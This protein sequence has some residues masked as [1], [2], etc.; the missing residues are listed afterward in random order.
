L[1][2]LFFAGTLFSQSITLTAPNG[3]QTW[4][5]CTEQ[6]ITWNSSGTSD[7]YSLD[8]STD[9]GNTWTS[10]TSYYNTSSGSYSWTVPNTSSSQCL[11]RITD[12][13]NS[14]TSDMSDGIF[15]ITSPL[16]VLAPNGSEVWEASTAETVS[17]NRNGTSN[18][19]DL[20][21]STDAGSSWNQVAYNKY[22]SGSTYNWNITNTPSTQCLF[23]ITDHSN[24]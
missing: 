13:N 24:A 14:G 22:I 10:I 15:T 2:A 21:Y 9:N 7:Y 16:T 19:F 5:G 4:A 23:K 12:S 20:Y 1:L 17:L 6:N 8:Y 11:I 3:G 18:Y